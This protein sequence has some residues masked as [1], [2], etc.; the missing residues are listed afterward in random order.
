[1]N[2]LIT[3]RQ[4][5]REDM[6]LLRSRMTPQE[7]SEA[8][9]QIAARVLELEPVRR[10]RTIMGYSNINN[11]VDLWKLLELFKDEGKTILL[12]RVSTDRNIEAVEYRSPSHLQMG[13]YGILEPTGE[14]FPP[15]DI[16][17]ALVPGLVYDARGHRLGYGAG[18]YDRFLPSL[19]KDTFMCGICYEYQVVNDIHPQES[20]VNVHWIVTNRSELVIDW[21]FF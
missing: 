13:M 10:A 11:E 12:P 21:D 5:L 20:D 4:S 7:V 9:E 8:S 16:D 14:V 2:D 6:R 3:I 15:Q 19:R 18:Y 1:M 17:V